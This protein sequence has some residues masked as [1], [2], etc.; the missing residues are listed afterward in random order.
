M[1]SI[2]K[3]SFFLVITLTFL[4]CGGRGEHN[5]VSSEISRDEELADEKLA[6]VVFKIVGLGE[7]SDLKASLSGEQAEVVFSFKLLK[8]NSPND[9]DVVKKTAPVENGKAEFVF[10][11][12]PARVAIA[13]LEI[14]HGRIGVYSNFKGVHT[15]KS[16]E[17]NLFL[18]S[19][20]GSNE[21]PDSIAG[22]IEKLIA[23]RK[24]VATTTENLVS[25]MISAYDKTLTDAEPNSV[26]LIKNIAE[27]Y[28][29]QKSQILDDKI[30]S[31]YSNHLMHF[32]MSVSTSSQ[33]AYAEVGPFGTW[34]WSDTNQAWLYFSG[35][36]KVNALL[37]FAFIDSSLNSYK[38]K[39]SST[40]ITGFKYG[41]AYKIDHMYGLLEGS[42]AYFNILKADGNY[43]VS[44][45]YKS[46][47][48]DQITVQISTDK[49]VT[50]LSQPYPLSGSIKVD[51]GGN[52]VIAV[53][54]NGSYVADAIYT[55]SSNQTV[56]TKLFL[57]KCNILNQSYFLE[58]NLKPNTVSSWL[59]KKD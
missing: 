42:E 32:L 13:N 28:L 54:F 46:S 22:A 4:G 48:N 45:I 53:V 12:L 17:N 41:S 33:D 7:N 36:S 19:G 21:F 55:D 51:M 49:L 37:S 10:Y 23:E 29:C 6:N 15:L 40:D 2:I 5:P 35:F 14:K 57:D 31:I 18:I 47:T 11:G 26:G 58:Y 27:V 52:G 38:T 1:R 56:S 16:G 43:D 24:I 39:T 8:P 30:R 44:G 9:F 25:D 20:C 59:G 50:S 34:S 3:L